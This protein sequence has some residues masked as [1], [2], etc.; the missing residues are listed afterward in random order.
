MKIYPQIFEKLINY[1]LI[2]HEYYKKK[3]DFLHPVK[4]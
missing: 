3:R 1:I 2:V 4:Q